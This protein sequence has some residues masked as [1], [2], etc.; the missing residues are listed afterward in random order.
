MGEVTGIA[1]A[2]VSGMVLG[3]IF[4]GGLWWTVIYAT[5]ACRPG[6]W[7]VCSLLLRTGIVII[8]FY[9]LLDLSGASWATLLA[10]LAGFGLAR[11]AATRLSSLLQVAG[12]SEDLKREGNYQGRKPSHAP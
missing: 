7:F 8:G 10:G 1:L 6:R 4:F 12:G 11:I 3:T 2:V 9:L 5:N